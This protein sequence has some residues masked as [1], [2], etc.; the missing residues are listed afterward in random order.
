MEGVLRKPDLIVLNQ[1]P[2][3]TFRNSIHSKFHPGERL[4]NGFSWHC[5]PHPSNLSRSTVFHCGLSHASRANVHRE[6]QSLHS[7]P[8]ATSSTDGGKKRWLGFTG[9]ALTAT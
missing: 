7:N 5:L 4:W 2:T 6:V 3:W 1:K 8:S 9:R